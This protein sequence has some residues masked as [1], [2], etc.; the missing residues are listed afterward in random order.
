MLLGIALGLFIL[1]L[2]LIGVADSFSSDGLAVTAL[3]CWVI[4]GVLI[5]FRMFQWFFIST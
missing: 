5:V 1:G 3:I 4:A 2:I